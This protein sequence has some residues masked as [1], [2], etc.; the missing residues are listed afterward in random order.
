M[1]RE[2]TD[3]VLPAREH[4]M[5]AKKEC[6]DEGLVILETCI[7]RSHLEHLAL[8]AQGRRPYNEI[9]RLRSAAGLWLIDVLTANKKITW[10]FPT[11][12]I[13]EYCFP[14]NHKYYGRVLAVDY[15]I[16]HHADARPR[17]N[18]N[19]KLTINEDEIK[20]YDRAG[21]IFEKYG[22]KWGGRF[23]IPDRLHI[24]WPADKL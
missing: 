1:L 4:F 2:I 13:P 7:M 18:W 15:C 3:L 11:K 6:K 14:K 10:T 9:C 22:F 21:Q 23:E 20:D 8:Y 12:H 19:I 5:A 24:E 17:Q 16:K